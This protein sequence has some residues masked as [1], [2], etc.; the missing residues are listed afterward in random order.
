[1]V[2]GYV[3]ALLSP[4]GS[5]KNIHTVDPANSTPSVQFRIARVLIG[6]PKA[7]TSRIQQSV[8]NGGAV[9]R[10]HSNEDNRCWLV[11]FDSKGNTSATLPSI[12]NFM[13]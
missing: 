4:Y 6:A 1:M 5:S 10:C 7:D 8:T 2:R 9:Y 13:Q 12:G 11:P 3:C